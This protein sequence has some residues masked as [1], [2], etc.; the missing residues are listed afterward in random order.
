M[1]A[2]QF[3]GDAAA[4]VAELPVPEIAADE[5]LVAARAVGICHSDIE[6]L[7]GRYII[8]FEYPVIAGAR[9]GGRDR[10]RS[11]GT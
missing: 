1:K 7:E 4:R 6:L 2:L 3:V 9:V 10:L 11:A 8:P 5:V